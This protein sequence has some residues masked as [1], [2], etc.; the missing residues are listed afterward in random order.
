M[1]TA[2]LSAARVG[3]HA[4]PMLQT[5]EE[6]QR[7]VQDQIAHHELNRNLQVSLLQDL[8][9]LQTLQQSQGG[10]KCLQVPTDTSSLNM[11][12]VV[13]KMAFG[14][15]YPGQVNPLDG[16]QFLQMWPSTTADC[17]GRLPACLYRVGPKVVYLSCV[18][19]ER[20]LLT[21]FN[22]LIQK[23][24]MACR[25]YPNIRIRYRYI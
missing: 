19:V 25:V 17:C 2:A 9:C 3:N 20:H 14:P 18:S 15:S 1:A 16:M 12:H 10:T 11:S 4:S 5:Q 23:Q 21:L 24:C 22:L 8:F 7:V 6:I 13:H